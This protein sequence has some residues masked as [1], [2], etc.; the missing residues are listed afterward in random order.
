V[1]LRAEPVPTLQHG[2]GRRAAQVGLLDR[3]AG[4][5]H[6][7]MVMADDPALKDARLSLLVRLRSAV[8]DQIGDISELA[9]E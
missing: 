5:A 2:C 9:G 6:E 3:A 1:T 4:D 7:V 8:L